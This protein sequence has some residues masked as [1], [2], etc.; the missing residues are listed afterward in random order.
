MPKPTPPPD[1]T[2]LS[3]PDHMSLWDDYAKAV[4]PAVIAFH[5][6]DGS[7]HKT[8]V[9]HVALIVDGILTQRAARVAA[10]KEAQ[11]AEREAGKKAR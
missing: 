9:E 8:G 3:L 4:L 6:C 1:L 10:A 11:L 5:G 2:H 7:S